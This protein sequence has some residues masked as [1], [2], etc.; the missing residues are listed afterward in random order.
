MLPYGNSASFTLSSDPFPPTSQI[1]YPH[2][3]GYWLFFSVFSCNALRYIGKNC[4]L[5]N[6]ESKFLS[7]SFRKDSIFP[8]S[9]S[10]PGLHTR[11][12]SLFFLFSSYHN[13]EKAFLSEY[14]SAINFIFESISGKNIFTNH[15]SYAIFIQNDSS[16]SQD[17]FQSPCCCS[18]P[19]SISIS[20][21]IIFFRLSSC[22]THKKDVTLQQRYV[23]GFGCLQPH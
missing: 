13:D 22:T 4:L 19:I 8:E 1:L 14:K 15:L 7:V 16:F 12:S 10:V 3:M 21:R 23:D 5:C 11:K 17:S 9:S 18:Y 20:D 6:E 2:R